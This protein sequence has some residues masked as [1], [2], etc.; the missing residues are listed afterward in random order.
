MTT[1]PHSSLTAPS[2]EKP[3][4]VASCRC[5]RVVRTAVRPQ[6]AWPPLPEPSMASTRRRC[7]VSTGR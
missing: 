5:S 2:G 4:V 1:R 7:W 6:P 3:V